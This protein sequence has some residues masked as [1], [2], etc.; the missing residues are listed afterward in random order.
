MGCQS[1]T[2]TLTKMQRS[3]IKSVSQHGGLDNQVK[4]FSQSVT[5][6][7]PIPT[8]CDISTSHPT[9]IAALIYSHLPSVSTE[10]LTIESSISANQ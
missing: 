1:V 5:E 3:K 4:Y 2:Q 6:L 10:D 8:L 9:R 7:Y